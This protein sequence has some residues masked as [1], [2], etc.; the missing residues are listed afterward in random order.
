[1]LRGPQFETAATEIFHPVFTHGKLQARTYVTA[2]FS[3]FV[4]L[5]ENGMSA[6]QQQG[7]RSQKRLGYRLA[8]TGFYLTGRRKISVLCK[9]RPV[10]V[11]L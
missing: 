6:P 10:G 2:A 4:F 8:T 9:N 5:C 7:E 1:M 11:T 3:M